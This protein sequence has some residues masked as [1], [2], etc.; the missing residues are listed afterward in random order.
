MIHQFFITQWHN[1]TRGDWTETVK[2]DLDAFDIQVDFDVI[3]SKS[4]LSFKN[5][6]KKRALECGLDIL[7]SKK[8]KHSKMDDLSYTELK[9]QSY[10]TLPGIK[11]EEVRKIFRFRVHMSQFGENFRGNSERVICPLC[12]SHLDNQA[13]SMQC[14]VLKEKSK[15]EHKLKD[16]YSDD[17]PLEVAQSLT[18]MLKIRENLIEKIEK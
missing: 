17:V 1:P 10:F 2:Q 9:L 13:M 14:P 6:V 11:I 4:K 12:E 15:I 16:I 3:R 7:L 8:E 18:R 5:M